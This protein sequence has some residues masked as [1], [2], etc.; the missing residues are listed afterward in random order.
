L[1]SST[2]PPVVAVT[3]A[4]PLTVLSLASNVYPVIAGTLA[5]SSVTVNVFPTADSSIVISVGVPD[6]TV[7][8]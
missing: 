5:V 1:I 3:S 6:T 8:V 2:E 7:N 4:E